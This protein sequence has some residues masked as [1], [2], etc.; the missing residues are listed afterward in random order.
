[1][2]SAFHLLC[3]RYSGTVIPTAPTATSVWDTFTFTF[4]MTQKLINRQIGLSC[5]GCI[6]L[7]MICDSVTLPVVGLWRTMLKLKTSKIPSGNKSLQ[8]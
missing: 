3:P 7:I 1:M 8:R 6:G 4:Y 2:G 5:K